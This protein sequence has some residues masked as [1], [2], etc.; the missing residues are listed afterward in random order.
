MTKN[1]SFFV[2]RIWELAFELLA[3][4][5]T[6]DLFC[7]TMAK[8]KDIEDLGIIQCLC[9]GPNLEEIMYP[10]KPSLKIPLANYSLAQ[11]FLSGEIVAS[12]RLKAY[13]KLRFE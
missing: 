12:P 4:N 9:E 11:S 2:Q 7:S 6:R 3:N 8:F 13:L 5:E 1:T 10:D